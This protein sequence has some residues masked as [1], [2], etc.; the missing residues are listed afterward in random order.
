MKKVFVISATNGQ[1]YEDFREWNCFF[2]TSEAEAKALI[3]KLDEQIGVLY[4]AVRDEDQAQNVA[5]SNDWV[6]T[7]DLKT[8]KK[9]KRFLVKN[10]LVQKED[11]YAVCNRITVHYA[12]LKLGKF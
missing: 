3:K 12:A 2:L 11:I 9:Y 5:E 4:E 1:D 7:Q 8:A 6:P 10:G